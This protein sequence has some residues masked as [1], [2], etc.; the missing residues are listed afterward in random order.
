ME[1]ILSST[2]SVITSL[3]AIKEGT[4]GLNEHRRALL[5]RVPN[6]GDWAKMNLNYVEVIDLAYLSAATDDEFALLWGKK[7][8]II[9]HGSE[10]KCVFSDELLTLLKAK[11]LRLVAHSHPDFDMI[12]PSQEDINFLRLIGQ[13]DSLIV[14]SYT[15]QQLRYYSYFEIY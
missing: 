6:T 12:C 3:T 5:N 9:L 14:S 10:L 2:N 11:A 13:K 15:G 1:G 7:S 4:A 8:D